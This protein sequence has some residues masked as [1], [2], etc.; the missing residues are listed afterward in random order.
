MKNYFILILSVLVFTL[1]AQEEISWN[2][3]IEASQLK[4]DLELL[5]F[6]LE[7]LHG[8]LYLYNTKA[9]IDAKFEEIESQ[10]NKPMLSIQFYN[11]ITP[12]LELIGNGHSHIVPSKSFYK[13]MRTK[14][15]YFPLDLY[16]DN[17]I[18]YVLKN[19]SDDDTIVEAS[20]VEKINGKEAKWLIN[21]M[22]SRMTRDGYNMTWPVTRATNRFSEFYIF[23][24][25]DAEIYECIIKSPTGESKTVELVGKT[26]K[27]VDQKR[28][29]KYGDKK[30]WV[31]LKEPAYT[32]DITG[33]TAVMTLRTFSQKEIKKHNGVK[34]KK[35]FADAFAQINEK[36]VE[37]L[38]ID[39][40][41]NGGGDEDPTIELF[42]HLYDK[43]FQFYK[44][45]YL[46]E[47]KIPN[48]KLYE[49]NIF[50]LNIYAKLMTKKKEGR[51]ILRSRG[52]RPYA[53]AKEQFTGD[54]IVLTDPYSFSATGEMTAILK[55]HNRV[56]FVGEEAGGNPNQNTSGAMLILNLPNS[57]LRAVVPVVVFEMNVRPHLNY[58]ISIFS[59][60]I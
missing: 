42:S 33:K 1:S 40:R 36:G 57:G 51:Y 6:N 14:M 46:Q 59:I 55:E 41:A 27:E 15:K 17:D 47:R 11:L 4:E 52:L 60:S 31:E 25:G 16:M 49:D 43:E 48:G 13:Q 10:L 37:D 35:W 53:P 24:Y 8:A 22:A 7:E 2:Q 12:L 21:D 26:K 3:K 58:S 50:W 5:K 44:D 54:V 39:M 30:N 23:N 20:V 28:T 34:S 9:V 45:V 19:N 29:E 18:V 56:T 38:I 32:L